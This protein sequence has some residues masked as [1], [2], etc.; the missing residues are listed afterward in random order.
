[1]SRRL[2]STKPTTNMY[3]GPCVLCGQTVAANKGVLVPS[4]DGRRKPAHRPART[5]HPTGPWDKFESYTVDGC[6]GPVPDDFAVRPLMH[7]DEATDRVTC[8]TC[9]RS[10]DD[11]ISTSWTP[12]P[13]GRC[14][15]EYFHSN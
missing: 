3:D 11:A 4:S 8:G 5:I 15:F 12:T 7:G 2:T 10:W 13:S 9:G 6:P 1:M 14:P